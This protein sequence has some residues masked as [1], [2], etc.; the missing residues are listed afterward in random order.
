MASSNDCWGI[1][2]TVASE[3]YRS[4]W[5]ELKSAMDFWDELTGMDKFYLKLTWKA[6]AKIRIHKIYIPK[7]QYQRT[8]KGIA[9]RIGGS[10]K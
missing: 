8:F 3:V 5:D 9:F 4:S 1:A 7:K 6:P 2:V 10:K